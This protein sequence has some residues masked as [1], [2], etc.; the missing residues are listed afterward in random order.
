MTMETSKDNQVIENQ[1]IH[2]V[3]RVKH[4]GVVIRNCRIISQPIT[5]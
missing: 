4:D 2:G 1:T 5:T 3:V